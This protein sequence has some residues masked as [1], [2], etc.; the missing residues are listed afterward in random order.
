M[1]YVTNSETRQTMPPS[2]VKDEQQPESLVDQTGTAI[3]SEKTRAPA[4]P[5]SEYWLP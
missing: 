2:D 4:V 3:R 5:G 1:W